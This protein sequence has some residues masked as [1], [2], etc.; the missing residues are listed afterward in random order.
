M[1]NIMAI[2]ERKL[3]KTLNYFHEMFEPSLKNRQIQL[4]KNV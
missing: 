2:K 4:T 1:K 3:A